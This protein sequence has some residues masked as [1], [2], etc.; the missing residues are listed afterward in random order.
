MVSCTRAVSVDG[1]TEG[2][3]LLVDD[4]PALLRGYARA[5]GEAGLVV[6]AVGSGSAARGALETKEFD[7]VICD[8]GLG[9]LNGI[10]VLRI[11]RARDPDL[12]VVLMT[13]AADV[14]SAVGAVEFGALRY[15]LK[16]LDGATLRKTAVDAVRFGRIA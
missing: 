15:L 11:A 9:G 10:D 12:P 5:L 13:A 8:I 2:R 7:L 1:S 4:E 16:P 6:D 14:S 3:V